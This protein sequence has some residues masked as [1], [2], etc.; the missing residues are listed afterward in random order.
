MAAQTAS[1]GELARL[2]ALDQVAD[3]AADVARPPNTVRAY[4]AAWRL[5]HAY[6]TEM[7][8]PLTSNIQARWS[9]STADQPAPNRAAPH[10][11]PPARWT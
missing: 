4:R 7:Q 1:A 10:R 5:W 2:T 6:T 3:A 8:I 9:G 11:L